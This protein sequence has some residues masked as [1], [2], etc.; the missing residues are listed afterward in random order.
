MPAKGTRR[1]D[2]ERAAQPRSTFWVTPGRAA[3]AFPTAPTAPLVVSMSALQ[4]SSRPRERTSVLNLR[5]RLMSLMRRLTRESEPISPSSWDTQRE[6]KVP[7]Y[8]NFEHVWNRSVPHAGF[9]G[10]WPSRRKPNH[11]RSHYRA[12][13]HEGTAA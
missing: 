2:H 12:C 10:L 11:A 6:R 1:P 3:T 7:A 8:E 13:D 4:R 9:S 5:S